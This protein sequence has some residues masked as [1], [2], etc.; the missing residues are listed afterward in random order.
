MKCPLCSSKLLTRDKRDVGATVQRRL[1]CSN[2]LT[3]FHTTEKINYEKLPRYVLNKIHEN[4]ENGIGV[5]K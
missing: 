4:I 2:C 3:T 1:E 5:S